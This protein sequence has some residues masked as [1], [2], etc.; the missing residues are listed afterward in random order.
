MKRKLISRL[1]FFGNVSVLCKRFFLISDLVIAG[2]SIMRNTFGWRNGANRDP[3][4]VWDG[5]PSQM[6]RTQNSETL[7]MWG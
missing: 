3:E 7:E 4:M 2:I 6:K 5:M 1:F